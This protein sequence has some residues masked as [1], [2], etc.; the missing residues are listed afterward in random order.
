MPWAQKLMNNASCKGLIFIDCMCN[1]GL[2]HNDNGEVIE[3]T[4]IRISRILRNIAG[5]YP[6]KKVLIYLYILTTGTRRK[7]L[8]CMRMFRRIQLTFI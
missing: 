6:F 8:C 5:Q 3:G 2:Y 7:L 1:S 4:P